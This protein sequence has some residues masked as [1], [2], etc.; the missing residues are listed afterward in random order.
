VIPA[1][2]D[3][4]QH[5]C[6]GVVLGD[7]EAGPGDVASGRP[8]LLPSGRPAA[9]PSVVALLDE[10]AEFRNY[11]LTRLLTARFAAAAS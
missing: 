6:F 7:H 3:G 2:A 4:L 1:V 11:T 9:G 10:R 5:M 8:V